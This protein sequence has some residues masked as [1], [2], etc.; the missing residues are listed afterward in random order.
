MNH[1]EIKSTLLDS[2][3]REILR[4][5]INYGDRVLEF[6]EEQIKINEFVFAEK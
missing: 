2:C 3:E 1:S 4:L 5:L 6:E